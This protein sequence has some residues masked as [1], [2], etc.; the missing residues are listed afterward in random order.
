VYPALPFRHL[1]PVF[2]NA[3]VDVSG[4]TL[5]PIV[6]I[7]NHPLYKKEYDVFR[8]NEWWETGLGV[9]FEQN[10]LRP[11][12]S[13]LILGYRDG[14]DQGDAVRL[15]EGLFKVSAD[16]MVCVTA[17]LRWKDSGRYHI[18]RCVARFG[19]VT[20]AKIRWNKTV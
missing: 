15:A 9:S 18:D 11:R 19:N 12:L 2:A 10:W 1:I 13:A 20:S 16:K 3:R 17:R 6:P 8:G 4:I 14:P 5:K 7:P